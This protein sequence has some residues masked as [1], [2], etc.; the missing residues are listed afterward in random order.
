MFQLY[1]AFEFITISIIYKR[2]RK[3]L[4]YF[5]SHPLSVLFSIIK[6]PYGLQ[7]KAKGYKTLVDIRKEKE[8]PD[9]T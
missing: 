1:F 9:V 5:S 2:F 7:R 3:V 4:F 6:K 8:I